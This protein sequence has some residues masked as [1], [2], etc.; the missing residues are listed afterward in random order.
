MEQEREL[1]KEYNIMRTIAHRNYQKKAARNITK[2]LFSYL[3][4]RKV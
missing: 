1:E 4:K 3:C 2:Q